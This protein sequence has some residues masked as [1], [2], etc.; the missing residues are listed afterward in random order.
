MKLRIKRLWI[1]FLD[2]DVYTAVLLV[3]AG[4]VAFLALM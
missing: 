1:R 4:L 3:L 2:S